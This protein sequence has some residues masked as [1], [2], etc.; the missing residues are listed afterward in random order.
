MEK[1]AGVVLT[2]VWDSLRGNQKAQVLDQIVDIQ[3]RLVGARF[4][5]FG[6]LYYVDDIPDNAGPDS[7][8]Y[9]D[10]AGNDCGAKGS[11]LD[12]PILAR[13]LTLGEANWIST[14]AHV[15]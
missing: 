15:C 5:R 7:S 4:A 2:D 10:L 6:S 13:S 14:G 8:V 12:Q 1:Q 11:V 3:Q 9:F